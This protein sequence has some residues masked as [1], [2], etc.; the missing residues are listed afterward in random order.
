M[1]LHGT[2]QLEEDEGGIAEDGKLVTDGMLHPAVHTAHPQSRQQRHQFL[3]LR[4]R[5][6]VVGELHQPRWT[7]LGKET[8]SY[9]SSFA[10]LLIQPAT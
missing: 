1:H 2:T 7:N 6:G 5:A 3:V 4:A 8:L 10:D 9:P